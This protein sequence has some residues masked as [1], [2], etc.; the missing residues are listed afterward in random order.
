MGQKAE[1][2]D[3][4]LN[5]QTLVAITIN[6]K[7]GTLDIYPG[8]TSDVVIFHRNINFHPERPEEV[9]WVVDGLKKGEKIVI[10]AKDGYRGMGVFPQDVYEIEHP[11]N[12]IRS[13]PI[14]K[15]LPD[16]DKWRYSVT[17]VGSADPVAVKDPDVDIKE[18]P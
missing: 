17:L 15:G 12:S 18:N 11:S 3:Q 4:V 6:R 9:R 14:Q 5:N 1:L 10:E 13:G 16:F 7:G 8:R 2:I